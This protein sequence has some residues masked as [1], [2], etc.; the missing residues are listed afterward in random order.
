MHTC[1]FLFWIFFI[2]VLKSLSNIFRMLQIYV[3]ALCEYLVFAALLWLRSN[4]P[5]FSL[6]YKIIF[7]D[8]DGKSSF[9]WLKYA[10]CSS[11][12]IFENLANVYA[13]YNIKQLKSYF[14]ALYAERWWHHH[15]WQIT[16]IKGKSLLIKTTFRVHTDHTSCKWVVCAL[17]APL[18][19]CWWHHHYCACR[20]V[21][22]DFITIIITIALIMNFLN[23]RNL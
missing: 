5:D 8:V 2:W 21:E 13:Q 16:L 23:G 22:Q 15:Q 19:L 17:K 9:H 10:M 11:Q 6:Y 7:C 18:C 4:Y 20:A 3:F 14:V 12:M 1:N